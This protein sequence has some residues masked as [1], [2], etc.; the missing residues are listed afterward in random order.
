MELA[1]RF[2]RPKRE[3]RAPQSYMTNELL[4]AAVRERP[5]LWDDNLVEYRDRDLK[6]RLW[7]QIANLFTGGSPNDCQKS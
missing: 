5:A 1:E 3:V 2:H 4:I 6:K 7:Q